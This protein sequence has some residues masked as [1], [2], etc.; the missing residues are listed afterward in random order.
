MRYN[1]P[2]AALRAPEIRNLGRAQ[3]RMTF[4]HLDRCRIEQTRT[5]VEAWHDEDGELWKTTIPSA[6]LAVLTLGPGVS[7][8]T[9]ALTTLHRSGTT[10]IISNA[11]GTVAH[12]IGRALASTSRWAV[13]QAVLHSD[14]ASRIDTARRLY[15]QRFPTD[16]L[17]VSV[18]L[19]QL[20]GIEGQRVKQAYRTNAAKHGIRG[21]KRDTGNRGDPTNAALNA[22]NSVLYGLAATICG[23]LALSPALG[24]IHEGHSSAFLFDLADIYKTR[25]TI[26]AAFTNS[27]STNPINDT[28]RQVRSQLHKQHTLNQMLTTT[29]DLLDPGLPDGHTGDKLIDDDG[30]VEGHTN[31]D[32]SK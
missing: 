17:P 12:Y 5:G 22:A 4:L 9:P 2:A 31:W 25:I 11:A 32:G 23:A 29:Q 27:K 7:I 20:R 3:D 24:F 10:V 6:N 1:P 18:T 19:R 16:Q 15:L 28:L 30:F 21:F 8:T 13:A 14:H 26:P